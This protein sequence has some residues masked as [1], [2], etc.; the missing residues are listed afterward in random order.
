MEGLKSLRTELIRFEVESRVLG[1]ANNVGLQ[2]CCW[3]TDFYQSPIGIF[4]C[5]EVEYGVVGFCK[6][7]CCWLLASINLQLAF[8]SDLKLNPGYK[9]LANLSGVWL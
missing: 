1:F 8:G 2:R 6:Y 9:G 4:V 7:E 5:F 3:A